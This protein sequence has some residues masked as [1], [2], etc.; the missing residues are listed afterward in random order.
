MIVPFKLENKKFIFIDLNTRERVFNNLEFDFINH[1]ED[2][3]FKVRE[4]GKYGLININGNISIPI[5]YDNIFGINEGFAVVVL[6]HK[7]GIVDT[8]GKLIIPTEY[9][10]LSQV[11]NGLIL[12]SNSDDI[13][14]DNYVN[15][16]ILFGFLDT[17]NN[18]KIEPQ[19]TPAEDFSENLAV[20]GKSIGL[21]E[22]YDEIIKYGY[23]NTDGK[24]SIEFQFDSAE[25]FK[26][27]IANVK[28]A[29]EEFQIDFQ[30]NKITKPKTENIEN[31]NY[32]IKFENQKYLSN[33]GII[34][35]YGYKNNSGKIIISPIYTEANE[36]KN[37][38]A[39][40]SVNHDYFYILPSGEE[41]Y[42][43]TE[44]V[45]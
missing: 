44:Y 13:L 41:L 27:G 37:G 36:F 18:I 45:G 32:P 26:N 9:N 22:N 10:I 30:G 42:Q 28:L 12:F 34:N 20:V 24:I 39:L 23:I 40:V 15:T 33:L 8:S 14:Y 3:F 38:L 19:Y 43:R 35:S 1:Y 5:I 25:S 2:S 11:S 4:N 16:G 7:L 17:N 6:N 29:N 21:D 31:F